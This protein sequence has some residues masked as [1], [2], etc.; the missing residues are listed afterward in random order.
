VVQ[1]KAV[2]EAVTRALP[3]LGALTRLQWGCNDEG[4]DEGELRGWAGPVNR[5]LGPHGLQKQGDADRAR[6][7]EGDDL[8]AARGLA[9]L[10]LSP[11]G[12]HTNTRA[13]MRATTLL[14]HADVVHLQPGLPQLPDDGRCPPLQELLV[15]DA[16]T[17]AITQLNRAAP[18]NSLTR[19]ESSL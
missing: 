2:T 7:L 13:H 17:A 8:R 12:Q 15:S 1:D 9:P 16:F 3:S 4:D 10:L 11:S 19:L 14:T 5:A 18:L 6:F